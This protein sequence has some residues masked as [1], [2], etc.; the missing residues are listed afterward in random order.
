VTKRTLLYSLGAIAFGFAYLAAA[1]VQTT[2][3]GGG[4]IL[5]ACKSFDPRKWIH[6]PCDE[7]LPERLGVLAIGLAVLLVCAYFA[8]KSHPYHRVY[9][10]A[11]GWAC[12][13][14]DWRSNRDADV[15]IHR[16]VLRTTLGAVAATTNPAASEASR[17]L[18]QEPAAAE[19]KT[20]PDCA[21]QVR[22]AA[23][24]C[25]FCGYEF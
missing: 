17:D 18:P 20:C 16:R 15:V 6:S 11:V 7:V 4:L 25:R 19:W 3:S 23:R 22:A 2:I 14:C 9:E 12:R 8:E 10:A 13:D 21:E 5:S 1:N 24:K